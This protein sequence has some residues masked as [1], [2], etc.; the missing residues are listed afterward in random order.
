MRRAARVDANQEQ[1]VSALRAAGA[2]VHS[3]ASVGL[4]I[5]DLLVG[6]NGFTVLM[7]IKDGN[8]PFSQQRLTPAQQKFHKEWTGGSIAVVNSAEGALRILRICK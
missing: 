2:S 4:G 3:L 8:K 7:E 6:Y 1:I 5:P